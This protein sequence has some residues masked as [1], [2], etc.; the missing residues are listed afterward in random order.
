[1]VKY[2]VLV[3]SE[4]NIC[5]YKRSYITTNL[6]LQTAISST[7]QLE[8]FLDYKEKLKALVGEEEMERVISEVIYFTVMGANDLANNYFTIPLRRHQYD[9]PSYVE[10]L[11]SSAVNFTMVRFI[12]QTPNLLGDS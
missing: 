11:V 7:G 9:L 5:C 4:T 8:L 3:S 6:L 10:F 2:F 1:M 12:I